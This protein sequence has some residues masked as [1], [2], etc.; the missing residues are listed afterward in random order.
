MFLTRQNTLIYYPYMPVDAKQHSFFKSHFQSFT[1]L[2]VT[3]NIQISEGNFLGR[4]YTMLKKLFMKNHAPVSGPY[5][6]KLEGSIV[7]QSYSR[8]KSEKSAIQ[9]DE[10][11]LSDTYCT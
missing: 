9:A 3:F 2:I 7:S 6:D 8:P 4:E 10:Q 1:K 11:D 5:C